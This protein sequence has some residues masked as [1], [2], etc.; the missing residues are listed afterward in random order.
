MSLKAPSCFA[1]YSP[2][3]LDMVWFMQ[4]RDV[5]GLLN[6]PWFSVLN[7]KG[8]RGLYIRKKVVADFT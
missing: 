5:F 1:F 6:K 2:F 8:Y 4:N 3:M 7:M